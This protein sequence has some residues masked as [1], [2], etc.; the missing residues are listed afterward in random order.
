[1]RD[2]LRHARASRSGSTKCGDSFIG[3]AKVARAQ[4]EGIDITLSPQHAQ[5]FSLVLHELATNAAKYGALSNGTGT[6]GISWTVTGNHSN[7]ILQFSWRESGGPPVMAPLRRGFG[8]TLLDAAF[9]GVRFDYA[10]QGKLR[11]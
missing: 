9:A 5:N 2:W 11:V 10:A 7:R 3:T 6:I 1:M 4:I 8:T